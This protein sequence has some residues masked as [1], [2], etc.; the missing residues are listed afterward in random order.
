MSKNYK[1]Y[2]LERVFPTEEE[3]YEYRNQQE[4]ATGSSH[5][6]IED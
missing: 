4:D 1:V 2:K 5:K 6:V 3:A